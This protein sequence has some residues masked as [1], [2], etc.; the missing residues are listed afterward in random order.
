MWQADYDPGG[1]AWIDCS[2]HE[3]SVLVFARQDAARTSELVVVLNLTPVPRQGYRVG[4]PGPGRWREVLN[5]DA[6][7]Y[8]GGNVGNQ[9]SV[10][11]ED[12]PWHNQPHSAPLTLPPMG[13]VVFQVER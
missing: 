10:L 4:L 12:Q 8:G 7:V 13:A 3:S 2:D 6:A 11:A 1:F 5:S 9:G